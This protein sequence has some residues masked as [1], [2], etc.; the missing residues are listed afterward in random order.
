MALSVVL[1]SLVIILRNLI[2]LMTINSDQDPQ[3]AN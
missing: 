2:F 1:Q 3:N